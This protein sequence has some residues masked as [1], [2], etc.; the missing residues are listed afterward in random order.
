MIGHKKFFTC[1]IVIFIITTAIM[2]FGKI[3]GKD[4]TLGAPAAGTLGMVS[5]AHPLATEAGLEILKQGGNAF[6]AAV[7]VAA[8]LNVVEPMSSGIGGYGT[9]LIYDSR[10]SKIRFLDS[11]GKIPAAVN[12]DVFR[13][14]YPNYKKNRYGPKAVSTPGNVN[15]WEAL[16]K[17]YGNLEWKDLFHPAIRAA[18][19]GFVLDKHMA[20]AIEYSFDRFPDHAKHIYGKNGQALK[21]GDRLVQ[22]N[23]ADSFRLI[24][25]EG[26]KAFYA[27]KLGKAI[28]KAMRTSGGFLT[29]EDLVNN[30]AEWWE[31]IHITYRDY[32]VYTASPPS[33]AFPFL[34][35]L[36]LMSRFDV[37]DLGHNSFDMLHRFLEIT[38]HA[39]WCRLRYAGDP[40]ISPPPLD[41]LL[42]EKYWKDQ[43]AQINM[44]QAKPF[45][46]PGIEGEEAQHTTHFVAADSEGNIVSATQTLGGGFGSGIMPEGTGI[47]LNNSLSFCTFEPKGN[48]MDAHPGR[49]KLSGDCPT[50]I[51]KNWKPWAAL[52]TPGGHTIGQTVPQMVM[53]LVD[54]NMDI[55]GA[56]AAPRVCFA[57]PDR[58]F[59]E[60]RISDQVIQQL[61]AVGHHIRIVKKPGGIGNAHGLTIE[62][63][64][65]GKPV[66]FKGGADPRGIGLAKGLN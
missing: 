26:A 60:E 63:G 53:N 50:I 54:F 37:A 61:K 16:S 6:D 47:W 17:T 57:E 23:L 28:D 64:K 32:E 3:Q 59:L 15:A 66:R 29:I 2:N 40:E 14:P 58:I 49:R 25:K 21:A 20:R 19:E 34:I 36:G 39:F 5:T 13:K 46:Y 45:L 8:T 52:G 44:S 62:Y 18:D 65:N 4:H 11:S 24:A 1:L 35:R 51:L 9:I 10:E 38:K 56:L 41:K 43:A 30:K 7:S 42:A 48:P 31:P 33:T 22:K 27:G 12:A 55:Q